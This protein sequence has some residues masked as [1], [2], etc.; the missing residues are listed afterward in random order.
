MK[1]GSESYTVTCSKCGKSV[2]HQA[3]W[4]CD[5]CGLINQ[6]SNCMTDKGG[7][8]YKQT[9]ITYGGADPILLENEDVDID[10]HK[11]NCKMVCTTCNGTGQEDCTYGNW[12]Q[13]N[14]IYHVR[15]CTSCNNADRAMHNWTNGVCYDCGAVCSHNWNSATGTCTICGATCS[16]SGATHANNGTCVTCGYK[17]EN[18]SKGATVKYKDI[19]STTHTPYYECSFAGCAYTYDEASENHTVTTWTD[20]GNGKHS[21]TCTKCN[22]NVTEDHNYGSDNKCTKCGS[23]QTCEHNWTTDNDAI[24]HWEKCTKCGETR[25]KEAH[26]ITTWTDNGNET[27]SGTCTKCNYKVTSNHNYNSSNKCTDCGA[28]KPATDCEHNWVQKNDTT[29]HWEECTKCGEVKNKGTHTMAAARD[30]GNGTHTK[31]CTKCN[32]KVTSNHSYN[33]SNKCKDC[34]VTKPQEEC[35]HNWVQKNDS[36]NHWEECTKCGEIKDQT[37][38]IQ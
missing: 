11:H 6:V 33:S 15:Y 12:Q 8:G 20:N 5:K 25:N 7:C 37:K 26:T 14:Q 3:I 17:Y 22:E 34:G 16:H 18:H 4:K 19:T 32:Y 24:N 31:T 28:T 2:M 36:T 10:Y 27:H 35:T 1:P 13:E 30:N 29:N 23:V 38:N 21:G 9:F